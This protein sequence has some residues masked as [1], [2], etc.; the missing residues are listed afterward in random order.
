MRPTEQPADS[1]TTAG[2]AIVFDAV[3]KSY[4]KRGSG[5]VTA[6]EDVSLTVAPGDITGIIGRSGAGKST[7][8]R[9]VNGLERPTAGRVLVGGRDVG[10]ASNA[11][12]RQI[13]REVGMIFQHF[14][15]LA[16]RTVFDNIALP[17]EIAGTPSAQIAPRVNELIDL[18]GLG[19]QRSRYPAELSGGQKQ[20]VGIARALATRPKVLLSDEATSA[21]DPETT[22]TVLALLSDINRELGLTILLITHEM[23][24]VRDIAS[25]V[26][27]LDK[28]RLVETGETYAVFSRPAHA[29]TRSFLTGITGVALP[30]FIADRIR[31]DAGTG[32]AEEV[33][34][35]TFTGN[36]A[37][38]P[39]LARLTVELG[40]PVNIL[41][42]AI[43]EIGPHPFGS[44]IVS[45]PA[46]RGEASRGFLESHGLLTE[47][48]GYVPRADQ[49]SL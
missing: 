9:M 37:T 40:V 29:T 35:I 10:A 36:H 6:L 31:P 13:R 48:L 42:G 47:V 28:G 30:R 38:D 17:L 4:P 5:T 7:L 1:A 41:A 18:V 27:V 34:Q 16:S 45:V 26:A 33:M 43:E 2:A 11:E 20:R 39:M 3:G 22:R 21:L 23:A 44:L 8:L 19:D 24:V 14:N 25:H 15:L 32:A 12:L 49:P 46:E